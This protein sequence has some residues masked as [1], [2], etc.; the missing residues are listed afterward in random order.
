MVEH[1]TVEAVSVEADVKKLVRDVF[2]LIVVPI[3]DEPVIVELF[4]KK[5]FKLLSDRIEETV[6]VD[7]IATVLVEMVE[8][9]NVE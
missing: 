3:I 7:V 2:E 4:T 6:R 8:P 5:L 1:R 9:I